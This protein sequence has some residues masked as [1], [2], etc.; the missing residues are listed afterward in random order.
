M[1]KPPKVSY[2]FLLS[3]YLLKIY[4]I[5]ILKTLFQGR[6]LEKK[7]ETNMNWKEH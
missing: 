4:I 2:T 5:L 6:K 7:H 3:Y 1:N